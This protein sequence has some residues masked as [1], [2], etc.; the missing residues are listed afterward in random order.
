MYTCI[1]EC[2]YMYMTLIIHDMLKKTRQVNTTQ[3]K[4]RETQRNTTQ[5]VHVQRSVVCNMV[6]HVSVLHSFI[7]RAMCVY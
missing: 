6:Y 1:A 5:L 4:D 7:A 3:Q 2:I